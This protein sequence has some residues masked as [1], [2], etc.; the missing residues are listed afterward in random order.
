MESSHPL[1]DRDTSYQPIATLEARLRDLEQRF[2]P[3]EFGAKA[4]GASDERL[5]ALDAALESQAD[6]LRDIE[7]ALVGRIADVDDDRRRTATAIQRALETH[8]EEME[9][10]YRRRA[11]I[12]AI[13]V[14]LAFA[15]SIAATT[16]GLLQFNAAGKAE[17]A[18]EFSHIQD[19]VDRLSAL[20]LTPLD[21]R[22]N[23]IE[24]SVAVLSGDLV[25]SA[26]ERQTGETALANRLQELEEAQGQV[27]A[28]LE[29]GLAELGEVVSRLSR[30][31]EEVVSNL[32]E[33]VAEVDTLAKET[34]ERQ[35]ADADLANKMEDLAKNQ[36][37]IQKAQDR[38]GK[39]ILLLRDSLANTLA[40][41]QPPPEQRTWTEESPAAAP[42]LEPEHQAGAEPEHHLETRPQLEPQ[43][44]PKLEPIPDVVDGQI[45]LVEH[46][47][48][49]QLISF[50]AVED[51]H[52]FASRGDLPARI[53]YREESRRGKTWYAVFY[54]L[55]QDQ[56][57]AGEAM[58]ALP[59]ELIAL[60]PLIR[61]LDPATHLQVLDRDP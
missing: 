38:L 8:R 36:E 45:T 41:A 56:A 39:D 9:E 49:L 53:Y 20:D 33:S 61:Q 3:P 13:F 5:A 34:A 46:Q 30:T 60:K 29:K 2:T 16:L 4:G 58:S 10:N 28:P 44:E 19:K 57:A 18:A 11:L 6:K 15:S 42:P 47:Y 31:Q 25:T 24:E 23:Q 54:S 22:L 40:S 21:A 32:A 51:L 35:A 14:F 43:S 26:E 1:E 59:A 12:T 50:N 17:T 52:R 27:A 55:Y 37:E 7:V 48:A